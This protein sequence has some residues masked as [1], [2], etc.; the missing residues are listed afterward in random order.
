M[1]QEYSVIWEYASEE[2]FTAGPFS[3]VEAGNFLA[4]RLHQF[5]VEDIVFN[6]IQ[7]QREGY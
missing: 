2:Q 6:W 4:N 5:Q 1:E 7:I 3:L